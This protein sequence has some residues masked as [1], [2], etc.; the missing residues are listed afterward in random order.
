MS[1]LLE[2]FG[3][4][5]SI[6]ITEILWH[7]LNNVL[8]RTMAEQPSS[9]AAQLIP[10]L[11]HLGNRELVTVEEEL[12]H[13]LFEQPECVY[14]RMAA[15]AVCLHHNKPEKAIEQAQSIYLR[16]PSNTMALYV[17]GYC[18]ER[19]GHIEQALEF[20]QDCI[21]FKGHLQLPR[22]R[23]AAI[24][25][26]EGRLD[27][28]IYEYE[29]VTTEHPDDIS[30]LVLL[31]HLYMAVDEYE[32]AIDT[33]NLAILSHP[34]NFLVSSD[35]DDIEELLSCGLFEQALE[36]IQW[37]IEQVGPMPDLLIRMADVYSQW[38]KDAEA[39]ACFEN[40]IR[41]QPNSLEATIKLG[42]HYLRR[43]RF[44][45]AAEQFNRAAE[46][47][48]EI[49]DAYLGLVRALKMSGEEAEAVQTLSLTSSIQQNSILLY[50][51]SA[52]LHFQAVLDENITAQRESDKPIVLINDVIRAYQQQLQKF[53]ARPDVHYKY[54]ILM[55]V[56][57]NLPL[58]ISEFQNVLP[59]NPIH[60][61][62]LNKLAV[63]HFDNGRPEK[64]VD[65]LL[66]DTQNNISSLLEMY[67]KTSIL[68][69]DKEAFAKAIQKLN[70][71]KATEQPQTSEIRENLEII[72][73]NLGLLDRA[74]ANWKRLEETSENLLDIHHA[75]KNRPR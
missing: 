72:L 20:Y 13:Y 41:V 28:V 69:C 21:K 11:E 74:F 16:Q 23:M 36:K 3:K 10:V 14:G 55:M 48:D 29:Q 6:E 9:P 31:G 66:N 39:I 63:C 61:R 50:S 49:V 7:W 25:M 67:Y 12:K 35:K 62:A 15:A 17:L 57:N 27:R 73:E 68:Y 71:T 38:E 42:T 37:T 56:E 2:I 24:Y 58:A 32:K 47:N 70:L 45:L 22:Q 75:R 51:E 46:I 40:A 59:L 60:Y 4:G 44:T 1:K 52:T 33:F 64:A 54:G 26:R 65:T 18:H 53:P 43:Q 34:D 5:I 19:L 30:S 8:S